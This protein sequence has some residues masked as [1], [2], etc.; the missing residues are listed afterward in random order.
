MGEYTKNMVKKTTN[1]ELARMI[2]IGFDDVTGR[3]ATKVDLQGVKTDLQSVKTDLQSVKIDLQNVK[4]DLESKIDI[5]KIELENKINKLE[6][7]QSEIKD[8][9]I[10]KLDFEDLSARVKYTE[11]KLG[12]ESGK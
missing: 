9:L 5:V 11:T 7:G 8:A 12:I 10:P 6:T 1:E 2:K 3:M 4:T